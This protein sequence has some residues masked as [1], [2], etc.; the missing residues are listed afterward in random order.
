MV[1]RVVAAVLFD[2][3]RVT[4]AHE[5]GHRLG[6]P[7]NRVGRGDPAVGMMDNAG[8]GEDLARMSRSCGCNAVAHSEYKVQSQR[9]SP[10]QEKC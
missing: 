6:L 8:N 3:E 9:A 1:F 5:G 10:L 4:I 2:R 7:Q